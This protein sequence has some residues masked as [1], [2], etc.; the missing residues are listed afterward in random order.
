MREEEE[1]ERR[2]R[3]RWPK[4]ERKQKHKRAGVDRCLLSQKIAR[5]GT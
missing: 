5:H 2:E 1:E 3:E 4:G